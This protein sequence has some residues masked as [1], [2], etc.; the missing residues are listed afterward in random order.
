MHIEANDLL[1]FAR[2]ADCGSFS[3][4]AEQLGLPKSTLSRR[5]S[6]LESQLGERLLQ[7]TTRKLLLTEFGL[8]KGI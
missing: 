3:R 8:G 7:R 1:M 6:A 2:V 5:L 4:A